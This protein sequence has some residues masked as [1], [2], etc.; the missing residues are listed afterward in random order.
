[1]PP[2][3][4]DLSELKQPSHYFILAVFLKTI[5]KNY[6]QF[7]L[8]VSL[9]DADFLLLKTSFAEMFFFS[10][11]MMENGGALEIPQSY[12]KID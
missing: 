6:Q 5:N 8:I 3:Y 12:S 10:P 7:L 11:A 9:V 2:D 4:L 1:M